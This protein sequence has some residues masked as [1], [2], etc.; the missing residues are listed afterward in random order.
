MAFEV[1]RSPTIISALI[2]GGVVSGLDVA[3]L[4]REVFADGQVSREAAEELFAVARSKATKSPEW[5]EFFVEMITDHVLWQARPTG[6]VAGDQAEWLVG[7]V[8]RAKTP[9]ALAALVNVLS[10]AHRAPP[11]L[12]AAAKARVASGWPGVEKALAAAQAG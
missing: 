7:Q 12:I 6:V 4:R 2:H 11:W 5:T 8:D 1:D 9:E 10:E 3:W